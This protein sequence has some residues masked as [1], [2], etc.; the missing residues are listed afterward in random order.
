M[1]ETGN[2]QKKRNARSAVV[3]GLLLLLAAVIGFGGYTLAKYVSSKQPDGSANVAKWGF[4]VTADS[5]SL[6]GDKYKKGTDASVVTTESDATFTVKATSAGTNVVA[7][8]TTGSMTFAI[9]GSAEVRA[10]I[11]LDFTVTND[12]KLVYTVGADTTTEQTYAPVKW[13]L[14][15][16]AT[17][18]VNGKTLADVKTELDKVKTATYEAGATAIDD[19]YTLSW[20]WAFEDNDAL[21]TLLGMVANNDPV[22]GKFVNGN[23]TAV[24]GS[25]KTSTTVGFTLNISVTQ[26]AA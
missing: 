14:K 10:Q 4:T 18:L 8:G 13:T 24:T 9:K 21:D 22:D 15:K 1:R 7:P 6:F 19:E 20:A 26:L 17:T 2:T 25:G 12:V 23:N 11:A 5:S 3:V 16:G